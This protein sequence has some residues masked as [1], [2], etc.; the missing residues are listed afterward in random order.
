MSGEDDRASRGNG[1]PEVSGG[2]SR[3]LSLGT[4]LAAGMAVFTLIGYWIDK[5][6]G[7]GGAGTWTLV[8]MFMGL[9]YGAY[10][11]W[12]VV[13]LL[14]RDTSPGSRNSGGEGKSP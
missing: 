9:A 4:N 14:N 1:H 12:K 3:A 13:R 5:K 7:G 6:R 8:G 10:E 2:L 11:V